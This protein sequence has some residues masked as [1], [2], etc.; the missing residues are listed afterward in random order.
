MDYKPTDNF[1]L[2]LSPISSKFTMMR[3][4]SKFNQTKYGI[5]AGKKTRKELGAYVKSIYSF[6]LNK[7]IHVQNKINLFTNYLNDP[8]NVDIDWEL[9]V[10]M[11]VT[12]LI[13]TTIS[14]HMIYDH[15]VDFPVYDMVD[16]EEVQVGTTKKLQFKELL[17]VGVSFRF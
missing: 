12:E 15:D 11:K 6:D 3:D 10:K 5:P 8:Q 16:G 2:L 1:T 14:T 4:T 9:T 13:N 7:D 17:S